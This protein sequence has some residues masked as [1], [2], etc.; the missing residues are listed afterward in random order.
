[1][2]ERLQQLRNWLSAQAGID[3]DS[4]TQ[5]AGDASFRRYY[6]VLSADGTSRIVMDAPPDHEDCRPYVDVTARL[7]SSGVHVPRIHA[8]D[9]EQ[10]FLLLEDF[11]D[12]QF[13]DRLDDGS[14]P[15][16]YG[17]AMNTLAAF[18][19]AAP[20]EG[21]PPYDESLLRF[22]MELFREWLCDRHLGLDLDAQQHAM[23]DRVFT[24]LVGN[25]LEQPQVFVHR[26]YHSRNLM[27]TQENSPGI[28]DFQDAV[29]GPITYD[30]VSLLKDA[31]IR[32]PLA[33][34]DEWVAG[35]AEQAQRSG[36][37]DRAKAEQFQRWFDLMG[38]QRHIKVAGIFA[39]LYRRDGK[40]AYLRDIPLVLDY[41]VEMTRRYSQFEALA[42]LIEEQVRPELEKM[43]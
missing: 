27:L 14:A 35:Y 7:A 33:R 28:I 18:Q 21:L 2:A 25:A 20:L 32:W 11:G 10:G 1:M 31:Y 8:Q 43:S 37:I 17:D 30:L 4:L 24:E 22:E 34:V 12:D 29:K 39:R 15:R 23:L 26:D 6:R 9:L 5:V 19:A 16:L 38:L 13:L 41:I 36:L 42:I 40:A 3:P